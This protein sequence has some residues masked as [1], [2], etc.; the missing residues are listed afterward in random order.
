VTEARLIRR[1]SS[2]GG[3]LGLRRPRLELVAAGA[4]NRGGG[5]VATGFYSSKVVPRMERGGLGAGFD[6]V[7]LG[8]G[9]K[10]PVPEVE[11][12]RERGH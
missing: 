2:S 5:D 4:W 8:G 12:G 3:V 1:T 10:A 9:R 6:L 7:K 11:D